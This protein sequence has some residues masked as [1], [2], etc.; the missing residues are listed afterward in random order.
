MRQPSRKTDLEA[1]EKYYIMRRDKTDQIN[2]PEEYDFWQA[3][4]NETRRKI[5]NA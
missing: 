5:E 4:A 3:K 2:D 1:I